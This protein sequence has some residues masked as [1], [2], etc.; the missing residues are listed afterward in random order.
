M[1]RPDSKDA[2][3]CWLEKYVGSAE[4]LDQPQKGLVMII[5]ETARQS[6]NLCNPMEMKGRE[7]EDF[8]S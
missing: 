1:I 4:E 3:V 6:T 7:S 5:K 2:V 8:I